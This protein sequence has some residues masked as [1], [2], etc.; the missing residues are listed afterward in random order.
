MHIRNMHL[1]PWAA[2]FLAAAL[3]TG[4]GVPKTQ[5]ADTADNG[6][7]FTNPL[8]D[9]TP[10]TFEADPTTFSL[11]VIQGDISVPVSAPGEDLQVANYTATDAETAWEYPDS[12]LSVSIRPQQDYLSVAITSHTPGDNRVKWP[13]VTGDTYY[14]PLGEGKRIPAGDQTWQAYLNGRDFSVLEQLSM[15]FWFAVHGDYGVLYIMEQPHRSRLVFGSGGSIDFGVTHEYPAID[16]EKTSSYRIY[17]TDNDPVSAAKLYRQYVQSQGGLLTL[18][19]KAAQNPNIRKLYGAPHIYLWGEHVI[20]PEDI[21]WPALRKSLDHPDFKHLLELSGQTESGSEAIQTVKAIADQDYVDQYQKN[22][23]CRYI[24]ELMKQD[25]IYQ[26]TG[27]TPPSE[28]ALLQFNM[29]TLAEKLPEIF[30]PA[31]QWMNGGTVDLLAQL[32]DAGIDRAWIGLNSW[33]QGYAKPELVEQEADMGYLI[34]PYDSY[35]SIHKP[36]EEQWITAAFEDK[37]LYEN[38]TI[39]DQKGEKITGFNN[40]GRKLAPILSLPSVRQRTEDILASGL[41]FNTWFIDCDATGE[42][43]DDYTPGRTTTQQQDLK[44]RLERMAYIRDQHQMVIGSEGGNDFAAAT[45]AFAHGIELPTFS[46]MDEDMK[47]NQE[48]PYYIGKY[49]NPTGGVAEHFAKRVPVKEHLMTIFADPRYDVPLYKLV[50]N[51]SVITT[52]HWDWSTFKIK[53][54]VQNRMLREVLYNVPPL[55]HLDSQEWETYK[56]AISS[57]TTFWSQFSRQAVLREMTGFKYLAEDGSVQLTQYGADLWAAAN[58]SDVPFDYEG[59]Q[60]PPHSLML[61]RGADI[62]VYTPKLSEDQL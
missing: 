5:G 8:S 15:P 12:G 31:D 3:L 19:E 55:Y 46:W 36:G 40:V 23:L 51:D 25:G 35:H 11:S 33:E 9:S 24:S 56:E 32:N 54:A 62:S 61:K 41:P 22:I 39:T 60:I 18:E 21:N 17:L 58:F 7:H 28:P 2:L 50:Y 48:S 10:V 4:C 26:W 29:R 52:Y 42:I 30:R 57:H 49:Y 59:T 34:G 43:F 47:A 16:P 53:G 1:K 38:A 44:A 37:T 20:S 6:T 13:H 14:L 27:D 45:I